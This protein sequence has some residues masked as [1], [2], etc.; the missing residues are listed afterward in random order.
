M[1]RRPDIAALPQYQGDAKEKPPPRARGGGSLIADDACLGNVPSSPTRLLPGR[2]LG[3]LAH[4]QLAVDRAALLDY[5]QRGL[6]MALDLA[7][8]GD[9]QPA[10]AG[11]LAGEV[12]GD[13]D[14]LGRQI[15]LDLRASLDIDV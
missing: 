4:A 2:Q 7:C 12:A 3:I 6:D 9:L 11:D 8:A 14:L 13:G 10:T 1:L 5:Q 15:G